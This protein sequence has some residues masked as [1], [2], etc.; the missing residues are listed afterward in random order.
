V[1]RTWRAGE[2]ATAMDLASAYLDRFPADAAMH[3]N[4]AC[5]RVAKGDLEAAWRDFARAVELGFDDFTAAAADADLGALVADPRFAALRAQR[6]AELAR[7]ARQRRVA[8]TAG[9]WSTAGALEPMPAGATPGGVTGRLELRFNQGALELR[10]RA[11]DPAFRPGLPWRGASGLFVTL[12][13]R[14]DTGGFRLPEARTYAFGDRR[15]GGVGAVLLPRPEERWQRV[16][17]LAPKVRFGPPDSVFI[18]VRIPWTSLPTY[19]PLTDPVLG[20]NVAYR[21][22]DAAGGL[23][24][25]V[26]LPD[27]GLARAGAGERGVELELRQGELSIP[28]LAGR[29]S[30]TI[31]GD[32]PLELELVAWVPTAGPGRLEI[33][34]TDIRDRSVLRGG[35]HREEID[36]PAGLAAWSRRADLSSLPTGP[37]LITA[38]LKLPDETE[39]SWSTQL[40]HLE[41]GWLDRAWDRLAIVSAPERPTVRYR[42]DAIE[43][44]LA[45]HDPRDDPGPLATTIVETG[46]LLARAERSGTIVPPG[47]PFLAVFPG[48]SG[49]DHL[50]TVHLPE[51]YRRDSTSAPVGLMVLTEIAGSEATLGA[52]IAQLLDGDP[53]LLVLVPHAGP[54]PAAPADAAATAAACIAWARTF[55]GAADPLLAG[56]DAGAGTALRVSLDPAVEL[57]GVLLLTGVDFEPWPD[58]DAGEVARRLAAGRRDLGYRWIDFPSESQHRGTAATVRR[59]MK[60]A[61]YRLTGVEEVPGGLSLSQ[62]A[63]R[64]AQWAGAAVRDAAVE[65]RRD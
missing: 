62:A 32:E 35:P 26:L 29:V 47:G 39:L 19:H 52:T 56:I 17:E 50:C 5:L 9:R 3:Y 16:A 43:T 15:G 25:L 37:F 10:L 48:P 59:A 58:A 38:R 13:A 53:D 7:S 65:R 24:R 12:G 21:T 20:L 23:R 64:I 4:R 31:V 1:A 46:Q 51:E 28:G 14:P 33:R 34:F 27:P 6:T 57:A 18:A 42:L 63:G 54:R 2:F 11:R 30:G 40:L 36:L 41:D 45:S 60:D 55:F 49:L 61:D 8:L 22:A 44:A